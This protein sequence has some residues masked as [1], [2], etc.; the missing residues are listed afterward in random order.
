MGQITR[1]RRAQI[2][3][4][5]IAI[6]MRGQRAGFPLERIVAAL[7]G[8]FP[9]V[10]PLEAW[11]LALGWSRA[12]TVA[13]VAD[14]YMA[15]GLQPP[16]LSEAMLCR[17]EHGPD[18]PGPEYAVMLARVYGAHPDQ[19]GLRT[20]TQRR[21][22]AF[23]TPLTP[24][25]TVGED[26]SD[27]EREDPMR[28]RTMIKAVGLSVPLQLLLN[29]EDALA[30][31]VEVRRP[32]TLSEIQQRLQAGRQQFDV[33][34]LAPLL[35][36]LPTMLAAAA[37]TAERVDTPAG[38]ALLAGCHNLAT[39]TLN[40]VGR[41]NT[42]RITADRGVLYAQRSGDPVAVAASARAM[43]M[44]L[45]TGGRHAAATQVVGR[46]ADT[47]EV[48]GLRTAPQLGMYLRLMCTSAYAQSQAGDRKEAFARLA[49]AERAAERLA[50][51]T[52]KADALPFV[53]MYRVN[54]N[55]ALGDA[56]AAV[57]AGQD[58]R[59]EMYRTPERRGRYHTDMA[60]AWWQWGEPEETADALLAA[61]RETPSEVR[62]RPTIRK[63]ADD[64]TA[65]HPRVPG[66][67]ELATALR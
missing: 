39:D 42:A 41:K 25:I 60:R 46:A 12:Q 52:G 48:M 21:R 51:L 40:K 50:A 33:G 57:R 29:L 44:M 28:R 13:Q 31:P 19:L 36:G 49:D 17:F 47:L 56:G 54:L 64:L 23:P 30:V 53:R 65:L 10:L 14:L 4:E 7:R 3:R 58:L 11:R 20:H 32:E 43:G 15:D 61:Y 59:P 24:V 1:S 34:A 22:A 18:R 26:E 62:D 5:A 63:V 9:E 6:R 35:G 66:V 2:Q 16:G 67:R 45:R 37:D 38:W 27:D 8:A 55:Y